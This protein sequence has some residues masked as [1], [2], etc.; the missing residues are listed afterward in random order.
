MI[1]SFTKVINCID[2]ENNSAADAQ[3]NIMVKRE[4]IVT[5]A[6]LPKVK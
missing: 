6:V 1:T 3:I 5:T 2:K 4:S